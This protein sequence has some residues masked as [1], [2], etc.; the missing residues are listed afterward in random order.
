MAKTLLLPLIFL[1]FLWACKSKG[2]GNAAES[3]E[4]VRLNDLYDSALVHHDAGLLKRI[5]SEDF[6]YTNPEGRVLT[7][8]EQT[9]SVVNSEINLVQGKSSDVKVRLYGK[10][11]VVTGLFTA[12]GSYRGNPLTVNERYTAFWIRNDT[13]WQMVAEQGNVVK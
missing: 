13:S 11:A 9:N 12:S 1:S 10:A 7:R 5:Y 8:D 3:A 6:I 4:L 2:K